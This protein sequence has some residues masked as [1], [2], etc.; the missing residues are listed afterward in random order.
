MPVSDDLLLALE[1]HRE[2]LEKHTRLAMTN[3][4]A[5]RNVLD[6]RINLRLARDLG[7]PCPRQFELESPRQIPEMIE[8]LGLPVVLKPPGS[9][10]DQQLPSF[11][12]KVL[13]ANDE[14][15]LRDYLDEYC[16]DHAFPL[17]QECATGVVHNL[18]CFATKGET[19]A[20]HEYQSLRKMRGN[21]VLR[22]VVE[23]AARKMLHALDWNGVAHIAFFVN[24]NSKKLLYMETNGRL[25][26]SVE[27][28]VH[29]GWDFPWWVYRYFRH[30]ES[31]APGRIRLGSRTC[32][33]CGD[34]AAL[35]IYLAGGEV[36]TTGTRPG[37]LK[38]ILQYLSG[39]NPCIHSDVF[40]L[41]DPMP[42]L[43]DHWQL[44]NQVAHALTHPRETCSRK[45]FSSPS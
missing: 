33:H 11:P 35:A 28:S 26:S 8:A 5:L 43:I 2:D 37:R 21:G 42:T 30:G 31:P 16:Q 14:E 22:K 45:L 41:R 44:A 38:A 24:P 36:P 10:H 4:L 12:F 17:F 32:W 27:G 29:A 13:Y 18:C 34:L 25:W 23:Q 6:K 39:F 19:V 7:I 20:A 40:R 15:E 1:R 3:S 9:R